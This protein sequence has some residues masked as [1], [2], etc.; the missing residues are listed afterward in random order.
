MVRTIHVLRVEN[1]SDL[2]MYS[3]L[4]LN[5]DIFNI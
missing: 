1:P 2:W 5:S 4:S 3:I